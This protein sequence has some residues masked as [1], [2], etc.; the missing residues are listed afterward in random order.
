MNNNI[1]IIV[2]LSIS[3]IISIILNLFFLRNI[4]SQFKAIV[5]IMNKMIKIL[6][7]KNLDEKEKRDVKKLKEIRDKLNKNI[8]VDYEVD[9][10]LENI[11]KKRN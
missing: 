11:I 7:H 2:F 1:V 10:N 6:E 3:L 5:I 4:N 9:I 8:E